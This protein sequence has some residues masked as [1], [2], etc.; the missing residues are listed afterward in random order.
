MP[1]LSPE[2]WT[3]FR[4]AP[5][6][7]TFAPLF[8]QTRLLV[9][10]I[11]RRLLRNEDDAHDAFQ[12]T[13]S[14]LL[15]AA[16]SDTGEI[17]E[18]DASPHAFIGR[19]AYREAD[20]LRKQSTRRA[21]KEATME[22]FPEVADETPSP[23]DVASRRELRERLEALVDTLP[24]GEREAVLLHFF[25][26]LSQTDIAQIEGVPVSTISRRIARGIEKLRPR[27]RRAG[28]G[29]AAAALSAC[30]AAARMLDPGAAAS[31]SASAIFHNAME[32]LSATG[33]G[34]ATAAAATSGGAGAAIAGVVGG[35]A[36]SGGVGG[37][38]AA[39][40]LAGLLNS[41]AVIIAGVCVAG[42]V[43]L[44]FATNRPTA[45]P[46]PPSP[47]TT[48]VE[49]AAGN[50][51]SPSAAVMPGEPPITKDKPANGGAPSDTDSAAVAQTPESTQDGPP[52]AAARF[53]VS[54]KVTLPDGSPAAEATVEVF[55]YLIKYPIV[56][57][58][59]LA[60][61]TQ[62]DGEG[63][64]SLEVNDNMLLTLVARKEG[65]A[66]ATSVLV[67]EKA[68][69]QGPTLP[70]GLRTATQDLVLPS[71][72]LL[73]GFVKDEKGNPVAGA[74]M[75]AQGDGKDPLSTCVPPTETATDETGAFLID[76]WRQGPIRLHV[77][78]ENYVPV[79]MET[80]TPGD[81]FDIRLA[82][83][84]GV[85]EGRVYKK[86]TGEAV[87]DAE[88]SLLAVDPGR[89]G[90][91]IVPA[92]PG[93]TDDTGAY[94]FD[95]LA[96]G[97]YGVMVRKGDLERLPAK[98]MQDNWIQLKEMEVRSGYD[99]FL[100]PGFVMTGTITNK[101]TGVP[102]EGAE[103]RNPC[104]PIADV[105][106]ASGRTDSQGRFRLE[107]MFM[108]QLEIEKEGYE[109][110]SDIVAE[111]DPENT[112]MSRDFQLTATA[113]TGEGVV[114]SGV[115]KDPDGQAVAGA[116]VSV[117]GGDRDAVKTDGAGRFAIHAPAFS[118][119][120]LRADAPG[121]PVIAS[122]PIRVLDQPV[123]GIEIILKK[124]AEIR[125]IVVDSSGR[126]IA[127]AR[128][129][130]IQYRGVSGVSSEERLRR[131]DTLADGTFTLSN[132]APGTILLTIEKSG[133]P[134]LLE[135]EV[136][137]REG[138]SKTD[139]RFEMS[140]SHFLAGR[141]LDPKG[142]PLS[143][144]QVSAWGERTTIRSAVTDADGAF[145]LKDLPETVR[146]IQISHSNHESR[147][148]D[149]P[150]LDRENADFAFEDSKNITLVGTVVDAKT[151]TPL[152]NFEVFIYEKEVPAYYEKRGNGEFRIGH[153]DYPSNYQYTIK[154]PGHV[155]LTV[156]FRV[157]AKSG[158]I[159]RVFELGTGGRITGR[160]VLKA[161]GGPVADILV[162]C[163]NL[164]TASIRER[165]KPIQ[166]TRTAQDGTFALTRLPEGNI[167]L[168]FIHGKAEL[169]R[170]IGLKLDEALDLGDVMIGDG[171]TVRGR[172]VRMP[173]NQP[174]A[175]VAVRLMEET[176]MRVR[177]TETG[178]DGVF[179]FTGLPAIG[180]TLSAPTLSLSTTF[181]LKEEAVLDLPLEIGGAV[182][183]GRLTYGARGGAAELQATWETNGAS[184][185]FKIPVGEDGRFEAR[186][187]PFGPFKISVNPLRDYTVSLT[188]SVDI[189]RGAVVE[190]NY[191]LP[192]AH[193]VGV[194]VAVAG[195]T[196][197]PGT[198]VRIQREGPPFNPKQTHPDGTA[199]D[200][201]NRFR[202]LLPEGVYTVSAISD[203]KTLATAE[204][205]HIPEDGD[206]D[207]VRLQVGAPNP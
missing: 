58:A 48:H 41:K 200:S 27:A 150:E 61:R 29:D 101:D 46:P 161:T 153:L 158:E 13:Y 90:F 22:T 119:A 171:S 205:V 19:L 146:A 44:W 193:L 163:M 142:N 24:D 97:T 207:P 133:Y 85:I 49:A 67:N 187:L 120:M 65:F 79:T 14:R 137:V 114:L 160:A 47:P 72:A 4:H 123:P 141:V 130:A 129:D 95:R 116:N 106:Q 138:E 174:L 10:T 113:D 148:F 164:E 183:R 78:A 125:G 91:P 198:Y 5:T 80:E 162:L 99:L 73:K 59:P 152:P 53:A 178:A 55:S 199:I 18:A 34:G 31:V 126:P 39:G 144:A 36:G 51:V 56:A 143:L 111:F 103:I 194:V 201:S 3:A 66:Q 155:P 134:S 7:E 96:P 69:G 89:Q 189:Q 175:G 50:P 105:K 203:G 16:A 132:I 166:T 54:G 122:R 33:T 11:C 108:P 145:R 82:S 139:V 149:N 169:G 83:Q 110:L 104:I 32:S 176:T 21:M 25:H 179:Q 8:E 77:N 109:K 197:P 117:D 28:L 168:R 6:E 112:E 204:G 17:A 26:G 157:D 30:L 84:G 86:S 102:I 64:Y 184:L 156:W 62:T 45:A 52:R 181:D 185:R 188:D 202:L 124:P 94:R 135:Q 107:G 98:S 172:F 192:A 88:L 159:R 92:R 121:Y 196:V 76:Q 195:G 74:R 128:V 68:V 60:G 38:A 70:P 2:C 118:S 173:E 57:T 115:V 186:Q 170:E 43:A 23:E 12:G 147:S 127:A 1:H 177:E 131:A 167:G 190:R 206:S 9:F 136:V 93:R 75:I 140:D 40:G 165:E 100:F 15:A 20:R 71:P 42:A 182:F 191:R 37:S 35:M 81:S 151:K 180:Y 87:A 154:A 63:R